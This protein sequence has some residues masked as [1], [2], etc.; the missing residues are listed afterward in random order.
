[1]GGTGPV[2]EALRVVA[3]VVADGRG[4]GWVGHRAVGADHVEGWMVERESQA[5]QWDNTRV[6][7]QSDIVDKG[8]LALDEPGRI[9]AAQADLSQSEHAAPRTQQASPPAQALIGPQRQTTARPDTARVAERL[10]K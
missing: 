4:A 7:Q 6:H 10:V 3:S 8:A 1:M 2:D 9:A 5:S